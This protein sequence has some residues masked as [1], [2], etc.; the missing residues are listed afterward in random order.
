MAEMIQFSG[1]KKLPEEPFVAFCSARKIKVDPKVPVGPE[2]EV[3]E[4]L[5]ALYEARS[6]PSFFQ[7][8]AN[9]LPVREAVWFACLA[10]EQMLQEGTDP[11]PTLQTAKAWVFKPNTDTREA[12]EKAIADAD[13][14]DPTTL[15]ADAAFHGIVKGL[16]AQV[17]SPPSASPTMVF[18]MLM[19]AA[20]KD[21]EPAMAE[22][23]WQ[24]LVGFG[25]NIAAGGTGTTE[26]V[27][28]GA[29]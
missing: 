2:A 5:Q 15:A 6:L 3:A 17:M 24:K 14:D 28:G 7:V 9:A 16:E 20:L 22:A 13:M 25:V 11:P 8:I 26:G 29:A 1:L 4:G 23:N 12:V 27:Q 10:A 21:D 19:Q 18:A